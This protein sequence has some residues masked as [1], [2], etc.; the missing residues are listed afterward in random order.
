MQNNYMSILGNSYILFESRKLKKLQFRPKSSLYKK[1]LK[2]DTN[3]NSFY[4]ETT[5]KNLS[6]SKSPC[7]FHTLNTSKSLY[8]FLRNGIFIFNKTDI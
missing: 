6:I 8:R 4:H 3:A 7:E 2:T 5:V 1:I